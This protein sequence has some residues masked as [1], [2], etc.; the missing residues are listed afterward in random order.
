MGSPGFTKHTTAS[1]PPSAVGST[2][3][4]RRALASYSSIKR[5]PSPLR[6]SSYSGVP[7]PCG[8]GGQK[9]PLTP[10]AAR[11]RASCSPFPRFSFSVAA[12][13]SPAWLTAGAET[14]AMRVRFGA[15]LTGTSGPA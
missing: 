6:H 8:F 12:T 10:A 1:S 4:T 5:S 2:C 15:R 3:R 11:A 7:Y 14:A 9:P 13:G